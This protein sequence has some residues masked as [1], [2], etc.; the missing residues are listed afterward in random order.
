MDLR[1]KFNEDEENYDKYRPSYVGELYRDIINYSGICKGSEVLEIGIGTGQATLPFLKTE[2][3]LTAVELG[4]KLTSYSR[5]KF[6]AYQNIKI[7]NADFAKSNWN[8]NFF[9]LVYSATAFHWI[10][11]EL[12][13][14]I[15]KSIL[16]S[17][18]TIA[19]FW[20]HPFPNRLDDE[21]NI[22]NKKIYNKYCPT[23]EPIVEFG[24]KDCQKYLDKLRQHGFTDIK[25]KLYYH[26]RTLK[27]KEY[28]SL[29][30]TYS[31][32]R[33]LSPDIKV[34][35]EKDMKKAIDDINGEINIYD[36]IDLYLARKP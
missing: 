1:M 27:S 21:T 18:G 4:D 10:P 34:A 2:C 20:N 14:S 22:A 24:E 3:N 28:I 19:L 17:N 23:S 31:D 36:T 35:F 13:Y 33:A 15:A 12:G 7:I 30:N 9:D 5:N 16:K 8:D 29:L 26:I 25:S 11:Q 32:H 6:S